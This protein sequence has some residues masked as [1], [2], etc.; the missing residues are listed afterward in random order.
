MKWINTWDTYAETE[1]GNNIYNSIQNM[2]KLGINPT[3]DMK[4][5]LTENSKIFR[6]GMN[7]LNKGRVRLSSR[8]GRPSNVEMSVLQT[9]G[10]PNPAALGSATETDKWILRPT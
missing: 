4:D 9:K 1:I 7:D 2:K 8:V 10:G 6:R 5:L 3:K